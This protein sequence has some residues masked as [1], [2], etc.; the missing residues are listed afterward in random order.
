MLYVTADAKKI[1]T[2]NVNAGTVSILEEDTLIRRGGP[3]GPPPGA[4]QKNMPP[5]PPAPRQEWME[6]VIPVSEGSEGF[7]VSPDGK[8]LWTASAQDGKI[9]V[10]NLTAKKLAATINANVSGANRLQFTP[11]ESVY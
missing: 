11:D 6:T 8:Q 1:Y 7:D 5:P 2:T 10:I 3:M 4:Q 9:F